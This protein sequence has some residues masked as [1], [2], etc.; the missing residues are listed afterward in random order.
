MLVIG[1]SFSVVWLTDAGT[2]GSRLVVI[3]GIAVGIRLASF[4]TLIFSASHNSGMMPP[5][6]GHEGD[7]PVAAETFL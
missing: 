4:T 6:H 5:L 2:L 7:S 1:I 3:G